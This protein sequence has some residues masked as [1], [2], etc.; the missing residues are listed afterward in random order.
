MMD[1][2]IYLFQKHPLNFVAE[3]IS[4]IPLL[5][6]IIF[7]PRVNREVKYLTLFFA[8][9]FVKDFTSD[10]FAYY[11]ESNLF[12]YNIFSLVEIAFLAAVFYNVKELDSRFYKKLILYGCLIS[13]LLNVI[14]LKTNEFS[15]GSFTITHVY[16]I[17]IIL[18]FYYHLLSKLYVSNIMF[19]S[20]FWISAGLLLYYSGTF[21]IFLLGDV[22]LST[23][24]KPEI[25]QQYWD[26]NLLFYILFCLLS[27]IGIWF[28]K[29]DQRNF[30]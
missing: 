3:S 12:I 7:W 30:I 28:S 26:T 13:L 19:Y 11:N 1:R 4:L 5:I 24:S 20:M 14:F 2:I 29:N 8:L 10:I 6:G 23:K 9:N 27:S 16:G 18:V 17:S 22:V 21:F 25:F 15:S